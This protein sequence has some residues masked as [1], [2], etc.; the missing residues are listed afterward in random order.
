MGNGEQRPA[1]MPWAAV[2]D[3]DLLSAEGVK[4]RDMVIELV[5]AGRAQG[6]AQAGWPWCSTFKGQKSTRL[7]VALSDRFGCTLADAQDWLIELEADGVIAKT[8]WRSPSNNNS[9]VWIAAKD[10]TPE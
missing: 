7:D 10:E 6:T 2:Q 3:V 5:K 1:L 8:R 9:D 4:V